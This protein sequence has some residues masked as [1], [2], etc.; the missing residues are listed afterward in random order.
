MT[1]I[2]DAGSAVM[3]VVEENPLVDSPPCASLMFWRVPD[4]PPEGSGA[5]RVHGR[6]ELVASQCV[7]VAHSHNNLHML[8]S[9]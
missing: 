5:E 9:L 2:R 6:S 8:F 3:R 4:H 1:P 7:R